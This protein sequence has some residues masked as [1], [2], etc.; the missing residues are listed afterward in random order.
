[1]RLHKRQSRDKTTE[2]QLK[3]AKNTINDGHHNRQN[4][5]PPLAD[6]AK[7]VAGAAE[8]W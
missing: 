7:S 8:A 4:L 5:L 6:L 3:I 1:M 2:S